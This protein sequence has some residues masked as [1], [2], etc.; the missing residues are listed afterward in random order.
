MEIIIIIVIIV[1][2]VM[3]MG[4]LSPMMVDPV[5]EDLVPLAHHQWQCEEVYWS[6][7]PQLKDGRLGG[8]LNIDCEVEAING[9]GLLALRRHMVDRIPVHAHQVHGAP[10]V[11]NF[12][13]LPSMAYDITLQLDA[14][15]ETVPVRGVTHIATNGFTQLRN[16]FVATTLPTS[17]KARYLKDMRSEVA[18]QKMDRPGWYRVNLSNTSQLARPWFAPAKTFARVF[19][20]KSEQAFAEKTE[21]ILTSL[22]NRL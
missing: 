22:A 16:V 18:V 3:L 8:T 4:G 6:A 11:E 19:K 15:G 14:E 12:Q 20:D 2:I 17:G 5:A 7:P 1:V 13:G 21:R 9:G 10:K